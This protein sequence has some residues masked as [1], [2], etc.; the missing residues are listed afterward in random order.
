MAESLSD[1]LK[2]LGVQVGA[3]NIPAPQKRKSFGIEDVIAGEL[4]QTPYGPTYQ[5][6]EWYAQDYQHG[7]IQ[8]HLS[9]PMKVLTDWGRVPHLAGSGFGRLLFLDTET[10][11]LGGGTGTFPFLIGLGYLS[12]K[13]FHL[14]QLLMRSPEEE[15]AQLFLLN[16]YVSQFDAIV[17]YNGKG[18]DIPLLNNR[19]VLNGFTSPFAQINHIDL[20]GLARRLWRNR[21]PSRSLGNLE[22]EVLNV[23]RTQEE[24]PGYLIPEIY[25]EYL[26][27]GDARPLAG[28][29]YHNAMDILSLA[30]L[31]QYTAGLLEDPLGYTIPQSLDIVAIARLYEELGMYAPAVQMYESGLSMGMPEPFF[32][33]TL[34]RFAEL[35]RKRGDWARTIELWQKAV[36]HQQIGACIELA[37]YYEHQQRQCDEALAWTDRAIG[38]VDTCISGIISR[39]EMQKELAHRKERLLRKLAGKPG[40]PAPRSGE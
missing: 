39:R 3:G 30:A 21:L 36:D 27:S 20:L 4:V 11:G 38:M 34:S 23:T 15:A 16:Q 31:Y 17:T 12:D 25:F 10:T 13:G 24:V 18:F 6:E 35:Y 40:R 28:V 29:M 7:L 26:R 37:K 2:S 8:F 5:V 9:L 14:I 22:I 19:H 1:K 33:D 32:V